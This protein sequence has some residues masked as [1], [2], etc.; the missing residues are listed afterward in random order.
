FENPGLA[1]KNTLLPAITLAL[2][3][4]GI[5]ARFI[6]ASLNDALGADY[7]RMARAKGVR[8]FTVLRR[9]AA[10][11]AMLPAITVMGIY[12]GAFLG[13]TVVTEAV[14]NYPGLGRLM[15]TAVSARDY[16]VIQGGTLFV[17]A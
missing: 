6:T 13:G 2:F 4:S 12:M 7:V 10:R 9:H 8:E 15:Y 5:L 11:N 3:T 16:P 14:F 1:A 17:V